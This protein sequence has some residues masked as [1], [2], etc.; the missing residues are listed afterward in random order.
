MDVA[1]NLDCYDFDPEVYSPA[2]YAEDIFREAGIDPDDPAF[3]RFDFIG[4]GERQM[5]Q[6][7]H[8]QTAY[9]MIIRN[10]NPFVLKYS[11]TDS[12]QTEGMTMQP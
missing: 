11:Q 5:Q 12:T 8:V 2:V 9:G 6:A 10:E 3:F 4:Y 1:E 7:G